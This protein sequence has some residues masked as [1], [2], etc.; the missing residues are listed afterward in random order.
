MLF[1]YR[2]VYP[3]ISNDVFIAPNSAVIGDVVIGSES[4]V[5]FGTVIRGDVMPI[6]IGERTNLQDGTIVHVT[7]G[8]YEVFIG[9]DVLIGHRAIIHGA[10]LKDKCFVG[11]A[12]TVLD[13]AVVETGGIVAAGALVTP[14]KVVKEGE[15]WAGSPAKLFRTVSEQEVSEFLSGAEGYRKLA[16]EYR[17]A[18]D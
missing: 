14:G 13:G 7:G 18:L 3:K 11:M 17:V 2:D 12:A 5:W 15:L 8:E 9:D 1:P 16:Q 4:S 6:R 10:T